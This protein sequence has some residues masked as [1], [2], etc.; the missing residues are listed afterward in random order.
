MNLKLKEV[1]I[2]ISIEMGPTACSVSSVDASTN[3]PGKASIPEHGSRSRP[4]PPIQ[5]EYAMADQGAKGAC[6]ISSKLIIWQSDQL[7]SL[8]NM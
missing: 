6:T 2:K 1:L 3:G 7:E 8:S 4:F 5:G